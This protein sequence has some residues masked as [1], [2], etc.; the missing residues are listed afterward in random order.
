MI[1]DKGAVFFHVGWDYNLH[2][3]YQKASGKPLRSPLRLSQAPGP[4][5]GKW[6][7]PSGNLLHFPRVDGRNPAS[8]R[9]LVYPIIYRVST[10]QGDAGLLPSTVWYRWPLLLDDL[11]LLSLVIFHRYLQLQVRRITKIHFFVAIICLLVRFTQGCWMGCWGWDDE[12]DSQPV[13]HSLY[14]LISRAQL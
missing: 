12:L 11:P 14:D 3:T 1:S 5:L 7:I 10:I 4:L 2:F 6:D 8:T 9:W 13:D